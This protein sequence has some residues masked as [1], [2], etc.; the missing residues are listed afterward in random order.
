MRQFNLIRLALFQMGF[1]IMLGF[2]QVTL[3]RVMT[4]DLGIPSTIV[5][6][7]ISLRELLAIMGVKVWAGHMSDKSHVFG[8]KRSPY[9]LLGLLCCVIPFIFMP[10]L[11][12][13]VKIDSL[14]QLL[15]KPSMIL[16]DTGLLKLVAVFIVFGFGLQVA[17]TAYYALLADYAG[18]KHIGKLTSAS[19]TLMILTTIVFVYNVGNYLEQYSPERLVNVAFVGGLIALGIGLFAF[20]GV[21]ERNA[22][23]KKVK[24]EKTL[25]FGQSIKL[26]LSSPRALVFAFY[27]F[28]S[29]Y[30]IFGY[31]IVM[32][33]FGA[34]VFGMPVAVTN[35][36]FEP[37]IK[38]MMLVFMLL[39]GFLLNRIGKKR[40]A[41]I[42]N[43]FAITGFIIIII[44]GF[45][46]VA[47]PTTYAINPDVD[48]KVVKTIDDT[49]VTSSGE[50]VRYSYDADSGILNGVTGDKTVFSLD[51]DKKSGGY[52]FSVLEPM[53]I[54]GDKPEG[55][56]TLMLESAKKMLLRIRQSFINIFG[57]KTK[58]EEKDLSDTV[59]EKALVLDLTG[60]VMAKKEIGDWRQIGEGRFR[61]DTKDIGVDKPL[62]SSVVGFFIDPILR[63]GL[64]ITG[65]G[66]GTASIS[67]LTM[68]MTMTAGR[69][70]IY[71]G[72]WGT[73]QSLA[74][75]LA[76]SG[77]GA[78]RDLVLELTGNHML[79]FAQIFWLEILA[80]IL[81]CALLPF[82]SQKKF[83]KESE[84]KI[85]EVLAKSGAD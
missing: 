44:A 56:V 61:V 34:E 68:M 81:S 4:S 51:L 50:V 66:L 71:I 59:K 14:M 8:Y 12:Y 1:G 53:V 83:E 84:V 22:S 13:E 67:N 31:E 38:G 11:A 52:R 18:E 63:I 78:I 80:F 42:G 24:E 33:P 60:T 30:G 40:G 72:I 29:I 19:W 9:I 43:L 82:I 26:L 39:V 77:A 65:I 37:T 6:G 16:M 47:N 45:Q 62:Q 75:F 10:G 21:E 74:I 17:T 79:A 41:L 15:L 20:I 54:P 55:T 73:A 3:N 85:A 57:D 32:E 76:H 28:V 64:I 27:I 2:L 25:S 70:G 48:R 58:K 46:W 5:F 49:A 7:L 23:P 35:K 69:S 36:L